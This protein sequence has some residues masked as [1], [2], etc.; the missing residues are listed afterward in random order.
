MLVGVYLVPCLPYLPLSLYPLNLTGN[1]P[2][3]AAAYYG[4]EPVVKLLLTFEKDSGSK[5]EPNSWWSG[6][7]LACESG[8]ARIAR[9]FLEAGADPTLADTQGMTP[10]GIAREMCNWRCARLLE[11]RVRVYTVCVRGFCHCKTVVSFCLGLACIE[12]IHER[13]HPIPTNKPNSASCGSH[14][15]W[16]FSAKPT[17]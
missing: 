9:L 13:L 15:A 1:T 4:Y 3:T 17:R 11:V 6:L 7:Y 5:Q 2:L 8:H 16:P 10:H 12:T 14:S